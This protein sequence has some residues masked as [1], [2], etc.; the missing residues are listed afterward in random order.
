[1]NKH[2]KRLICFFLI[3]CYAIGNALAP[4]TVLS[5]SGLGALLDQREGEQDTGIS[6]SSESHSSST[7]SVPVGASSVDDFLDVN[8]ND[9]FYVYLD[10]LVSDGIING[11]SKTE[12]DPSGT[13]SFAECSAVITRYLGL[14]DYAAQKAAI[15]KSGDTKGKDLWY[16]GY[17]QVMHELGIFDESMGIYSISKDTVNIFAD[18]ASR[19]MKRHEFATAIARSFE[20]DGEKVRSKNIYSEISGLGHDFIISGYYD[21][22]Y[23]S[24]YKNYIK[25]YSSIPDSAK[26]NVLKVYYNGIF[27]G[28]VSGYFYPDNNLKRSEMAKVLA[29]ITDF[30]LR[31]CLIDNYFVAVT[32]DKLFYDCENEVTL[33]YRYSLEV[34]QQTASGFSMDGKNV[35]YNPDNALPYGYAVDVYLY[36]VKDSKSIPVYQHTLA[37]SDAVDNSFTY[38]YE[39]DS[40]RAILVLRNLTDNA[41]PE[42]TLNVTLSDD[43]ILTKS[44]I[45]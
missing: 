41:K 7:S 19:P 12:F 2:K 38:H 15:I 45:S 26:A 10:K 40:L 24:E 36:S 3:I 16:A 9:W 6:P 28:D 14:D 23:V 22:K 11:K 27:N 34:L 17:F 18:E 8:K 30:S 4:L 21:E 43:G 37:N 39:S 35:I 44:L 29:T 25:D 1:M 32:E 20:L 33:N 5:Q 31:K 13:F 42:F